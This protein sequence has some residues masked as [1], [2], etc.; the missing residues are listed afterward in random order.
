M[1]LIGST[2]FQGRTYTINDVRG[3]K[4]ITEYGFT[5]GFYGG[6]VDKIAGTDHEAVYLCIEGMTAIDILVDED[7]L[8]DETAT[9]DETP[10]E[11]LP[12]ADEEPDYEEMT[13]KDLIAILEERGA[14][15]P[16]RVTK[17]E[18]IELIKGE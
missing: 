10:E 12:F 3:F 14:E 5:I 1:K 11:E 8:P 9:T 13:N 18:L 17:A 16:K 6:R 7:K 15:V 4:P 2:T